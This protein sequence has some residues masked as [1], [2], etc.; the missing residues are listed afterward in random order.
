MSDD[1]ARQRWC[2]CPFFVL[3]VSADATRTEI[4]RA[5]QKLL[6]EIAIGRS[7]ALTYPT[8]FGPRP[9]TESLVRAAAAELRD[10]RRRIAHEL[11]ARVELD[12]AALRPATT[13]PDI[14]D[15]LGFGRSRR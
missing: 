6:A 14:L 2:E 11:W 8:P 9:R 5:A 13:W 15:R 1:E 3:G 12:D 7:G 10:P 4:E